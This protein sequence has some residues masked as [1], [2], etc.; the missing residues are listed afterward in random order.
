MKAKILD[1]ARCRLMAE[2]IHELNWLVRDLQA[3]V[4]E[5]HKRTLAAERAALMV[6]MS[7]A[8]P[9]KSTKVKP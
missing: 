6:T 4:C 9:R 7:T 2:A 3:E 5:L 1:N 8:S